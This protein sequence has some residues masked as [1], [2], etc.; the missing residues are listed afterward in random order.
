ME[1]DARTFI[2][3]VRNSHDRL[4][5]LVKPLTPQELRRRSY[6]SEWSI[7]Q[8]LSHLGSQA[9]IFETFLDAAL[10]KR[11][12][13]GGDS[14][15]PIWDA[16][17]ARTPDDQA[18]DSLAA[19]ETFVRHLESTTDEQLAGIQLPLFGREVDAAGLI[20]M[21][22]SE[23]AVHTWDVAVALD[24][25]AQVSPDAI[26]LL[27]DGL[28]DL[29]ARAGKPQGAPFVVRIQTTSPDRE[30]VLS[31]D[32]TGKRLEKWDAQPAAAR[33]RMP[34][35]ALVRLVYGRLDEEHT[36]VVEIDGDA[37]TLDKLR[38]VFPGF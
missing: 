34:A 18:A 19:N 4:V 6:A 26:D 5:S 24:P 13:P 29:V 15:P 30:L 11:D 35:E 2:S 31:V 1:P 32:D 28:G 9:E 25:S 21:R 14:F 20:R 12:A 10:N 23:H 37:A 3:S 8:V 33:V 38:Q 27:I 7:A 17:N 22:L 36:P 16:W